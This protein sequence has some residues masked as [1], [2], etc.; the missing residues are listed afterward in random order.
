VKLFACNALLAH[1]ISQY[2]FPLIR[3]GRTG[4]FL[5]VLS[6]GGRPFDSG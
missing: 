2:A 1:G 3:F 5:D 6:K 4:N